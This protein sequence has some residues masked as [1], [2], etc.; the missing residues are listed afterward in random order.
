MAAV[1]VSSLLGLLCVLAAPVAALASEAIPPDE[2]SLAYRYDEQLGWFPKVNDSLTYTGTRRIHIS[3][4]EMGFRDKP[5][6]EHKTRPRLIF[7]GDS[8]V[9]GYDV[10]VEERFTDLL[11]AR[12]ASIE[13][14]NLGVSG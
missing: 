9:W 12:V 7:V 5:H 10:E 3:H 2:R 8:F 13:V 11:Q 4:N 6:A 14:L 1:L